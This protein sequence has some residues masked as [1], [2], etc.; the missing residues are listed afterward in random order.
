MSWKNTVKKSG[1][2]IKQSNGNVFNVDGFETKVNILKW[3]HEGKERT[4]ECTVFWGIQIVVRD[5]YIREMSAGVEKIVFDDG[6]VY[7][8]DDIDKDIEGTPFGSLFGKFHP[9]SVYFD[10]NDE[11]PLVGFTAY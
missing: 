11:L 9:I 7:E 6:T 10:E 3:N 5:D 1:P 8:E 4:G 2:Q